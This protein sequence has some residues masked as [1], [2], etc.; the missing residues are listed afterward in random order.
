[1]SDRKTWRKLAWPLEVAN[2]GPTHGD[3]DM[4][5]CEADWSRVRNSDCVLIV[6]DISVDLPYR[7][8]NYIRLLHIILY[9]PSGYLT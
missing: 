7:S 1:M 6:V 3:N 9:I 5:G 8:L 4:P 2:H